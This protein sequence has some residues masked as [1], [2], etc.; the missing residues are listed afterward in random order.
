[1]TTPFDSNTVIIMA[2][3][4]S[5]P[6]SPQSTTSTEL[7]PQELLDSL[8]FHRLRR[9]AYYHVGRQN[10][11]KW[12]FNR[13]SRKAIYKL[14]GYPTTRI[15][16]PKTE[17]AKPS[18]NQR[19]QQAYCDYYGWTDEGWEFVIRNYQGGDLLHYLKGYF[20][21]DKDEEHLPEEIVKKYDLTEK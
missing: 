11:I 15:R 14:F 8:P 18:L 16:S 7:P 4:M 19:I 5:P 3:P 20:G 21:L 10:K 1:M 13:W 12:F 2:P 9:L 17:P 6:T